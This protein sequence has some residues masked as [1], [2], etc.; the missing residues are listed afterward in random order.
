MREVLKLFKGDI[1]HTPEFGKHEIVENG[2]IAVKNGQVLG[3]Y[4]EVPKE[5][6]MAELIDHSGKLIIPGFID[7]HF[8]APQFTNRGLGLDKELLPWLETYTF[9]EEAKYEN[10]KYAKKAYEKVITELW[11][12]G[13]TRSVLFGTI[14]REA[15]ELLMEMLDKSG[16]GAMVGKVNMD[17]NA[18]EFYHETTQESLNETR[19]WLEN[20]KDRYERVKPIITPRF[21]PTCTPEL[22]SGLGAMAKEF[23]VKIQSHLSENKG[24]IAWVSE[25]EPTAKHYA[26]VYNTHGLFGDQPTIQAHCIWNT[27]EELELMKEKKIMV[28]H[29][30]HS[31]NNLSSGIAP[32]RK[33]VDMG[34][35]VGLASDISGGHDVSIAKAIVSASQVA[36]L[37]WVYLDDSNKPL[38]T[39]EWFYIATKGGGQFFGDNIGSFEKGNEFDAL[40][41]DDSNIADINPRDVMERVERYIYVG[42]DR[43]IVER[44]V[45]GNKLDKPNFN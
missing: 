21:V 10:I 5:H 44:Y 27:K 9:P 18:P 32:I 41:I 37:R 29:S 12:Q 17:R 2:Y 1:Y 40:I 25:L 34:I 19:K 4:K 45:S 42:D 30:P 14:H 3:V 23:N 7:T 24:E 38:S 16:L 26:D 15:T 13:T 22:L 28:A 31:N 20:T 33:L 8:H 43:N 11:R 6:N 36:K 35:P 39:S